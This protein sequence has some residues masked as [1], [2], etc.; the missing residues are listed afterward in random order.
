MDFISKIQNTMLL[1]IWSHIV[2]TWLSS[3]MKVS[4]KGFFNIL[5]M[6]NI[7]HEII[8]ILHEIM[9]NAICLY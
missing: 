9:L 6:I 4:Q 2:F 5:I 1:K 3:T 8:K 7:L